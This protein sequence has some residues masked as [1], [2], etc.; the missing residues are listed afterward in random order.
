MTSFN[1]GDVNRAADGKFAAKT[2]GETDLSYLEPTPFGSD[3]F[4]GD[5]FECDITEVDLPDV[6]TVTID[7]TPEHPIVTTS[8]VYTKPSSVSNASMRDYIQCM[9]DGYADADPVGYDT[10]D[11]WVATFN[12]YSTPSEKLGEVARHIHDNMGYGTMHALNQDRDAVERDITQ[13]HQLRCEARS[14]FEELRGSNGPDAIKLTSYYTPHMAHHRDE[15]S[16]DQ[17]FAGYTGTPGDENHISYQDGV[18]HR[19]LLS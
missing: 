4:V 3:D 12:A 14:R 1:E 11:Q 8:E 15:A 9:S 16:P 10:N 18:K 6:G 17:Y 5:T 2:T 19:A 13:F 7:G